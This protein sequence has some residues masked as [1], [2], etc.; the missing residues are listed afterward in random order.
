MASDPDKMP[1]ADSLDIEVNR[2]KRQREALGAV[3]LRAEEDAK[4]V[5]EEHD[6]LARKSWIWKRRSRSCGP[7]LPA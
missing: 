2:L 1:D 4:T 5:Q 6:T 3:N 7:G